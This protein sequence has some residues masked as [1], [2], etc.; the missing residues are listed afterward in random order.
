V[1]NSQ[2][3]SRR[4]CRAEAGGA[5]LWV[6]LGVAAV[7]AL[8]AVALWQSRGAVAVPKR[9]AA[10]VEGIE[11]RSPARV[12]RLMSRDYSDRWGFTREDAVEALADVGSQF[13]TLVLTADDEQLSIMGGEARLETRLRVG[14]NPVGPV[15]NEVTRRVN[16]LRDPFVFYWAKEGR[17]PARWRLVSIEQGEIPQNLHGYTPGDVRRAMRGELEGP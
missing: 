3:D 4:R 12:A 1:K 2:R 5:L 11:R 16:Q 6:C 10:L 14:G 9:Q 8:F 7:L 13:M 15:G 17:F